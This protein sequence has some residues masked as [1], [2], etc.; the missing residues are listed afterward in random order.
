[1]HHQ[2]Q[3]VFTIHLQFSE[4]VA[5]A[6]GREFERTVLA[7][8]GIQSRVAKRVTRNIVRRFH[9]QFPI[10]PSCRHCAR[11]L[12]QNSAGYGRFSETIRADVKRDRQYAASD[13]TADR[14]WV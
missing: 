14:L 5:T 1:M 11:Q 6:E 8:D 9:C 2:P 13:V 12:S 7:P 4:V 10:P 3:P